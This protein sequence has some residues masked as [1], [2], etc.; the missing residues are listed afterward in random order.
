[1]SDDPEAG[2]PSTEA[3][4][5]SDAS[6]RGG[7]ADVGDGTDA[8]DEETEK[9]APGLSDD[10]I[11]LFFAAFGSLLAAATASR[12]GQPDL[13]VAFAVLAG[14]PAAVAFLADVLSE[15]VP[16]T[17]LEALVGGTALVGAALAVPGRHYANVATLLVASAL[18]LWR[19]FD[20]EFRG[21]E[22]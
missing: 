15:Y 3:H 5:A 11:V 2:R 1:M 8:A 13:V 4:A 16:G 6:D 20:V 17:G 14:V 10:G 18:V 9:L 22:C 7:A 21:A 12:T 19:V